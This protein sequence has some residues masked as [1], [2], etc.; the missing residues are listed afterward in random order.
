MVL[1]AGMPVVMKL[2]VQNSMPIS[3]FVILIIRSLI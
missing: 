3:K 2:F 1:E